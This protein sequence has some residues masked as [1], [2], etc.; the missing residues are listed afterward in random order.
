M[1]ALVRCRTC[2]YIMPASQVGTVCPACG[3]PAKMLEPYKDKVSEKRRRILNLDIHPV[4]VHL[5][6]AQ[7]LALFV[8]TIGVIIFSGTIE[9]D[10]Q[11]TVKVVGV[12]FPLAVLAAILSGLFDGK[13]RFRRV[14]TPALI[15]K[16]IFGSIF[17]V[18]SAAVAVLALVMTFDTSTLTYLI[19]ALSVCC[20][21]CGTVLG[22][23]GGHIKF[24][25]FPG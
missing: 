14:T 18:F 19:L 8:F 21:A 6:Q 4:I 9:K 23:I 11:S 22:V 15:R 20:L 25:E 1:K 2:G 16:M 10:L 13:T 5:P 17:F 24:A 7:A 12:L 3:V